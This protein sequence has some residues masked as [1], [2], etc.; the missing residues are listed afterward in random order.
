MLQNQCSTE[1]SAGVTVIVNCYYELLKKR[2]FSAFF[3]VH[4]KTER[5]VDTV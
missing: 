1:H 2:Y 5:N 4:N 3:L